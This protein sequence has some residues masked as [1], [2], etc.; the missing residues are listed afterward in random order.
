MAVDIRAILPHR[1]PFL[2]V[3][4]FVSQRGDDFECVKNV[5][6]NEPFFQG[7]FPDEPVMPGVLIIEALAQ[8][9]AVGVAVR[10][11]NSAVTGEP[12]A[13]GT[14]PGGVGY[15]AAVESAKFRRKVVPGD[16]L[17]LTGTILLFRR[18]LCKV[19]A[20][21]LVGDEIAAETELSFVYSR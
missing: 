3:D 16:V 8:A 6:F 19:R 13:A 20:T 14:T 15:L 17:R 9:A 18:G 11:A 7:H 21:A 1:Y 5:S 2:M 12:A 4:A 10:E